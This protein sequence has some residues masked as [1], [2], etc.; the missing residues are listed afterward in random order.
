MVFD[1]QASASIS[2]FIQ[3]QNDL[4]Q[5]LLKLI[6]RWQDLQQEQEQTQT[7]ATQ[8]PEE[9]DPAAY[10]RDDEALANF[11]LRLAA[12][13]HRESGSSPATLPSEHSDR[14]PD[15]GSSNQQGQSEN[16]SSLP[17]NPEQI[18][19]AFDLEAIE[20]FEQISDFLIATTV[21]QVMQERGIPVPTHD[22]ADTQFPIHHQYRGED[23][24]LA[25]RS[26]P[27]GGSCC[28]LIAR[29]CP[30]L[31]RRMT[32]SVDKDGNLSG[33]QNSLSA[34]DMITLLQARIALEQSP[35]NQI[36]QEPAATQLDKLGGLAPD[37]TRAIATCH[38]MMDKIRE[39]ETSKR[40]TKQPRSSEEVY[41]TQHYTFQRDKKGKATVCDRKTGQPIATETSLGIVSNQ[42]QHDRTNMD[43][44]YQHLMGSEQQQAQ[45][46]EHPISADRPGK[47]RSTK[48]V[49]VQ[50]QLER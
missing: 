4:I 13:D 8:V 20:V 11:D 22:R 31:S 37:G 49:R 1:P 45:D 16:T 6:Q 12:L 34:K 46:H 47:C 33:V 30:H 50:V 36:S 14:A 48:E 24:L 7:E 39:A 28:Y 40:G 15:H 18:Y 9:E 17:G 19:P 27:D 35:W 41:A 42:N 5:L 23:F 43:I 44:Y 21:L 3:A 32:I 10:L 29:G 25:Q 26:T 2:T 38:R